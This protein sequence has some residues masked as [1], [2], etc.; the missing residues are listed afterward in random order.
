M[1]PLLS[2]AIPAYNRPL[3]LERALKSV[4]AA[5]PGIWDDL[6]IVITDDSTTDEC[7]L[8]CQNT[9]HS[10]PGRWYHSRNAQRLGMTGNW[11]QAIQ[12]ASGQYVLVLH[13]DDFLLPGGVDTIIETLRSLDPL[14]RV[15]QFGVQVVDDRGKLLRDQTPKQTEWLE[16]SVAVYNLLRY[17]SFIRFP[18]LVFDR[19]LFETLGYFDATFGGAADLDM[20]L[21]LLSQEGIL[22]IDQTTAAYTVH[23]GALT[24]DMFNPQTIEALSRIFAKAED[25]QLLKE[26]TLRRAKSDFFHQFILAGTFR[27]LRRQKYKEAV[28]TINLFQIKEIKELKTSQKWIAPRLI[29]SWIC[30]FISMVK[31]A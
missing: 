5:E 18:G 25:T 22:R 21:R 23:S 13:D 4:L 6:E 30:N 17:S 1:S 29:F 24:M 19:S 20:W 7:A 2:I 9:L 8:V 11:N 14:R 28:Q 12:T 31:Q 10:W 3:W 27:Y 26:D 16:P 15:I